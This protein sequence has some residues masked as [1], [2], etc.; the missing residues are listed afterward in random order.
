MWNSGIL[1]GDMRAMV[2]DSRENV[3]DRAANRTVSECQKILTL[4]IYNIIFF[5]TDLCLN[6]KFQ[7]MSCI[8]VTVN[9]CIIYL[10]N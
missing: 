4:T 1:D 5:T 6:V 8:G 10:F 2:G 3:D 7:D 9:V